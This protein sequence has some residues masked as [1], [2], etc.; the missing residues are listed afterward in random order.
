MVGDGIGASVFRFKG[1][2]CGEGMGLFSDQIVRF[3]AFFPAWA[4]SQGIFF[5]FFLLFTWLA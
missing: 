1:R 3:F 2:F 4:T 5:F